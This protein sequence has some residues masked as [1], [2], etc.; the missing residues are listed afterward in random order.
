MHSGKKI[1]YRKNNTDLYFYREF[2]K[3][4]VIEYSY[5]MFMQ[6]FLLRSYFFLLMNKIIEDFNFVIIV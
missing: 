5:Q 2:N 6:L 3:Y 4:L 1:Y